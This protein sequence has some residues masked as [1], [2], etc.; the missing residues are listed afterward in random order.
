MNGQWDLL[1]LFFFIWETRLLMYLLC[2]CVH[3]Q[4]VVTPELDGFPWLLP[5]DGLFTYLR[6]R[7]SIY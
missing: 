2:A 6:K 5:T 3:L 4:F 1:Y 7:S